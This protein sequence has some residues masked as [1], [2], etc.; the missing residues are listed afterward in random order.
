M[1]N[2]NVFPVDFSKLAES[3][4]A[5]DEAGR[6]SR[7]C[8]SPIYTRNIVRTSIATMTGGLII[9]PYHQGLILVDGAE[10]PIGEPKEGWQAD[11]SCVNPAE[12][13]EGEPA[14]MLSQ[15]YEVDNNL[16]ARIRETVGSFKPTYQCE[17]EGT[18]EI[19]RLRVNHASEKAWE[20]YC[21]ETIEASQG[22]VI[23][24][25]PERREW[26]LRRLDGRVVFNYRWGWGTTAVPCRVIDRQVTYPVFTGDAIQER[27]QNIPEKKYCDWRSGTKCPSG[28]QHCPGHD[29]PIPTVDTPEY[30]AWFDEAKSRVAAARAAAEAA[31]LIPEMPA[32]RNSHDRKPLPQTFPAKLSIS[33]GSGT[34]ASQASVDH[35]YDCAVAMAI[36]LG[37][38]QVGRE[39]SSRTGRSRSSEWMLPGSADIK[40]LVPEATHI[41]EHRTEIFVPKGKMG[42]VIGTGGAR[43]KRIRELTG[44][45]W[46]VR[47]V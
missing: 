2:Q 25:D 40:T 29:L 23:V 7:S 43:I 38:K 32:T 5:W 30:Q 1:S 46:Q 27:V 3:A 10:S 41:D 14:E 26:S 6:P 47:S 11:E 16:L 8:F 21:K 34:L 13:R 4:V 22:E 28:A 45:N 18:E 31:P 9:K 35:W 12:W 44:R 37:Y 20:A 17:R 39:S 33:H 36:A 42:I 19:R 24:E 15:A